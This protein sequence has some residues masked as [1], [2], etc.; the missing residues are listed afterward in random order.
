MEAILEISYD[1][2]QWNRSCGGLGACSYRSCFK[3]TQK[4]AP[5][6]GTWMLFFNLQLY[7]N[8][9]NQQLLGKG[10][11]I[12]QPLDPAQSRYVKHSG[13]K[14]LM[15]QGQMLTQPSAGVGL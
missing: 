6:C 9:Q 10:E 11:L 5:H 2:E 14:K 1:S 12:S 3:A 13:L 15:S 7:F 4:V 8:S